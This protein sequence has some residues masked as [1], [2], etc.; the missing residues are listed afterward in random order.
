[1]F[2]LFKCRDQSADFGRRGIPG[3]RQVFDSRQVIFSN[4]RPFAAPVTYR[5]FE[6]VNSGV[7]MGQRKTT[8]RVEQ[9]PVQ[10]LRVH[11]LSVHV[12]VK[13]RWQALEAVQPLG[14]HGNRWHFVLTTAE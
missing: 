12:F 8:H 7:D 1:M 9:F 5:L 10:L 4:L 13:V 3:K 14:F 11:I 2:L 6:S